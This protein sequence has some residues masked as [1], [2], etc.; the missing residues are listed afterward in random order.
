MKP[1]EAAAMVDTLGTMKPDHAAAMAEALGGAVSSTGQGSQSQ[2]RKRLNTRR[3]KLKL[4]AADYSLE[5]MLG[6]A[7]VLAALDVK[8]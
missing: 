4:G 6:T 1:D 5:R 7:M 8:L 2:N 3:A